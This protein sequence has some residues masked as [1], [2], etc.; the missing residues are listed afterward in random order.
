MH[1]GDTYAELSQIAVPSSISRVAI[2]LLIVVWFLLNWQQRSTIRDAEEQQ[3]LLS[4]LEASEGYGAVSSRHVPAK[5]LLES[6]SSPRRGP[7]APN[8]GWVDYFYGFKRL[9]Y[10]VW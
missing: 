5:N 10:Y 6:K 1:N 2:L 3:D 9:F 7:V 4:N 8:P